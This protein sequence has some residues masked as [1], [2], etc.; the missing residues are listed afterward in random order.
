[1]KSEF[2]DPLKLSNTVPVHKKEDPAD[3]TN[4][5]P[6]NAL[7]LI[8]KVFEKVMYE[9]LYEYLNNYLNDLLCDF[10]KAHSTQNALF[11]LI[12]SWKE[13][14]DNSVLMETILMGLSKAYE[15]LPHDLLIAKPEAY[16]LDKS[17][18]NLAND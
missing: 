15:C 2:P 3:K 13:E 6:V 10:H 8:S 5:R 17:S 14:L 16:S 11:R 18:L 7:R 12:L 1:M 9:R 4:Y